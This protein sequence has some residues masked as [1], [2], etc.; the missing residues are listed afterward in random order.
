MYD[1]FNIGPINNNEETK[2]TLTI[3]RSVSAERVINF[4]KTST[5]VKEKQHL[6]TAQ[7]AIDMVLEAEEK[8]NRN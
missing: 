8:L 3:G 5:E 7:E 6:I 4:V 2:L 1:T